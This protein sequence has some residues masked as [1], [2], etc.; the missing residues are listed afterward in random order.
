M[1]PFSDSEFVKCNRE[2]VADIMYTVK[3][4]VSKD[5]LSREVWRAEVTFSILFMAL[6]MLPMPF[7]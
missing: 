4:E 7:N 6:L 2:I 3:G 1:K 5:S